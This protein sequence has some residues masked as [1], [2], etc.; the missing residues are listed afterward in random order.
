MER[1]LREEIEN[2]N[3]RIEWK[4]KD[5]ENAVKE[6]KESAVEYDAYHIETFIPGMIEK[7]TR[8]R[9]E[10]EKLAGQKQMLEYML[11]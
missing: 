8:C 7:I 2:I 11:L 4:Q 9:G 10:I 6:F 5:L 1:K 3:K